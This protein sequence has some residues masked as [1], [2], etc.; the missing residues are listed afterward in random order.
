MTEKSPY[1]MAALLGSMML[2]MSASLVFYVPKNA[3]DA[4]VMSSFFAMNLQR[5]N[6]GDDIHTL[7]STNYPYFTTE[8]G[9]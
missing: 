1:M 8:L 7:P 2:M 3:A 5:K 6:I 9:R 4:G